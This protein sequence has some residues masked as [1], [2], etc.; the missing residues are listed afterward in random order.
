[1]RITN[2][3]IN[4]NN[5]S[6]Y[7]TNAKG[8]Y[9]IN[10]RYSSG[11]KIQNSYDNSSIYVDGT[12]LEYEINLL[13]QVKQTS[14]KATEFS[15]NSDK[16]LND[17]VAKLTEF[18]TKLIQA[19]N[20]IHNETSRNAIA[21][22]LEG[23]KKHLIDIANSSINGQFLFSGTAL[24]TKPIDS[25]GNYKGN[26][27]SINAAIGANQTTAYNIDG[28]TLFLGKDNDYKKILTT[29][30]S[31]IDNKTKLTSD[32]TNYLNAAN[33]ILDLI[34]GNYRSEE[35]VAQIGKMN[36]ELDFADP[37]A[38]ADTTFYMQGRKPNGET[39]S[40][41]FKVTADSSIQNLLDNIGYALG[42]DKNGKNSVVSVTINNSGQIEVT[43]LK[44]GNQMTEL[45]LFGLTDVQGPETFKV[46][47]RDIVI[48]P[49]THT[50]FKVTTEKRTV[51]GVSTDVLI[52]DSVNPAGEKYEITQIAG[53]DL[54]IQQVDKT[55]GANI[56]A[57]TN[58][59]PAAGKLV[60]NPAD[61]AVG[62][63]TAADFRA[64][65]PADIKTLSDKGARDENG[66]W[67][68]S[69]NL[70]D[71]KTIT[72]N[73]ENGNVYLTEFIKSGFEDVLGNKSDAIDY[74]KLQFEK[75]DNKL[76]SNVS[77][78]VKGTNE[79]ATNSTK[80][81][82]V[83]G[84]ALQANPNS[85]ITMNI[86]SKDGTNYEVKLNFTDT[87]SNTTQR[88]PTITVTPLDD[89]WEKPATAT[90][91]YYGNV[92]S[93]KY[94]E[95]TKMTDGVITQADDMTYQQ[96]NDIVS[97][98]AAGNLPSG[99]PNTNVIANIDTASR[100][101]YN[102][103]NDLKTALKNGVTDVQAQGIIDRVVDASGIAYPIDFTANGNALRDIKDAILGDQDYVTSRYNEYNTAVKS[104]SST[105][106]TTL[107]YRGNMVVTDKTASKTDIEVTLFED[108]GRGNIEF[109]DMYK[110]DAAGNIEV[111]AAGNRIIDTYQSTSGS[112][113][114]FTSNNAI[115]IDEPSVDIFKDLDDMIQAVRDGSYRGNP[116]ASDPRTTG[117]QGALKKIDHLMDH[118][119]KQHTQI[120]SYTNSLTATGDRATTLK[121]NVSSVKSEIMEADIGETY[122]MF[123]QRLLAYQAML[124][125]TAKTS[126]ISLLNYI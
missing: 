18:K 17:F 3:L 42:N 84:Q 104:A 14:T 79:Y 124:Q 36:P 19:G 15:K 20:N 117:I 45:H 74:N 112:L 98:V 88:Y 31:L 96:L 59:T 73:V 8:I 54:S 107:D 69:A 103:A 6:N 99:Q 22:D 25:A 47:D 28:Q 85:N 32:A 91:V 37:T 12:R 48:D 51:G 97:M 111:D 24:D 71:T 55:T 61:L 23:L 67:V 87:N 2:Q 50:D 10:E 49:A 27:Q 118:I 9:D 39:F 21:N 72:Q 125:A 35:L 115:S 5:L 65:D 101:T 11:L 56:G 64:Y 80:L 29:N 33:K 77:Q 76:S 34:G 13:D 93:G 62:G 66:N 82:A 44:S 81:S 120:G 52:V 57:A 116:D 109:T 119:N 83:A 78:V 1:M 110:R 58:V 122:L 4:F 30:V 94:N 38:L 40:T 68:S 26:N 86:K 100:N 53:G 105:I 70:T 7:Q 92:Y 126:Q 102:T 106:N 16:A 123:Q 41:K 113:F 75:T 121:V 114:S 90:P 63:V 60:L 108:H 43:D 95:A 89:N 46:G